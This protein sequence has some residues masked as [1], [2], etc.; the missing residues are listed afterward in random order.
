[1]GWRDERED[2]RLE[3]I[4]RGKRGR[5]RCTRRRKKRGGKMK[6]WENDGRRKE[7]SNE[8]R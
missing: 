8:E 2:G 1:M 5:E 4:R 3:K 6:R 7:E